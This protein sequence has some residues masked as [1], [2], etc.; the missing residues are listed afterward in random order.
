MAK[1]DEFGKIAKDFFLFGKNVTRTAVQRQL[2]E[3][4]KI[5]IDIRTLKRWSITDNWEED[6]M[7]KN[8][9]LSQLEARLKELQL[10]VTKSKEPSAQLLY[11]IDITLKSVQQA[12][13][14]ERIAKLNSQDV[15]DEDEIEELMEMRKKL[16]NKIK[17]RITENKIVKDN[18]DELQKLDQII[19]STKRLQ[20]E[21]QSE[22]RV[23]MFSFDGIDH[24]QEILD[25]SS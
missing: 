17:E 12:K 19:Q 24:T 6:R 22:Q 2:L 1:Y 13:S 21:T 10:Q 16:R 15:S 23:Y 25:A 14:N 11:A 3:K 4:Y 18:L 20:R 7:I 8:F 5:K 9:T